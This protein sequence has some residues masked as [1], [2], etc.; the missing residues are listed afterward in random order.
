MHEY[1][2]TQQMIEIATDEAK[3]ANAKKINK[4]S[5]VVG[6]LTGII[7]ESLKFYF[8]LL[9]KGTILEGSELEIINKKAKL[10]CQQCNLLFERTNTFLC[11]KCNSKSKLTEHGKEFYIESIEVDV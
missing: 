4:I 5:V 3:K 9:V 6:E 2:V 1:Y 7:D 10:R 8:D 11:P